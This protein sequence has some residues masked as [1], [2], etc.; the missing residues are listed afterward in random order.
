MRRGQGVIQRRVCRPNPSSGVR[1]T[2]RPTLYNSTLYREYCKS[3]TVIRISIGV[4]QG[5]SQHSFLGVEDGDS[6]GDTNPENSATLLVEGSNDD[7]HEGE[8]YC[9]SCE[10][11]KPLEEF[12]KSSRYAQGRHYECRACKKRRDHANYL[13]HQD[14]I[15]G[16]AQKW[17][18]ENPERL[19]EQVARYQEKRLERLRQQREERRK[20]RGELWRPYHER[21]EEDD[22]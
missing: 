5:A 13:K 16:Q 1:L 14:Q 15:K 19:A 20:R 10:T 4:E 21:R 12:H 7:G 18:D 22:R 6:E 17:R 2:R 8:K 9:P 11:W 3:S